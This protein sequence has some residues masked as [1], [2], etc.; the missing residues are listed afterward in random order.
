M[1]LTPR[2]RM[3]VF[4]LAVYVASLALVMSPHCDADSAFGSGRTSISAHADAAHCKHADASHAETCSLC[5]F[6]AGKA[7]FLSS[8]LLWNTSGEVVIGYL[9]FV[10]SSYSLLFLASSS[11]R[12]PPDIQTIA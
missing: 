3:P 9:P 7:I 4:L 1:P 2:R 6:F 11:H 5:S 8:P 10:S 12:G